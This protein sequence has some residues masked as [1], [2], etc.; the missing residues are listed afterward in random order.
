MLL[1]LLLLLE[2]LVHQELQAVVVDLSVKK[3]SYEI[4][5]ILERIFVIFLVFLLAI[6]HVDAEI[7]EIL[8]IVDALIDL[9]DGLGKVDLLFVG[10]E[11]FLFLPLLFLDLVTDLLLLPRQLLLWIVG[12]H[13]AQ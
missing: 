2:L 13:C 5:G 3:D 11:C 7:F 4:A 1:V 8:T 6:E 10:F 9:V 12:L